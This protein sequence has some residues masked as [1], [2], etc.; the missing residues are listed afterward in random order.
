MRK[1][2][3]AR[4]F[5][6]LSAVMLLLGTGCGSSGGD[7]DD[8]RI[9]VAMISDYGG[10]DDRS[11]N[12]TTYE[13]EKGFCTDRGIDYTYFKPEGDSDAERVAM[14]DMAAAQRY[15]VILLPGYAFAEPLAEA[16]EMYPDIK[17]IGLDISESD[18]AAAAGTEHYSKDNV[19]SAVYKEQLSGFMAGYMAVKQGY[20]ELGF[21]GGM[22]VPG[23]KRA[24]FGFV[25][26]CDAAAGEL[27][28]EVHLKYSYSNSFVGDA[29]ITAAMDM[30]YSDKT[31]IV[32]A[33]GG[34]IYTSVA[35]AAKKTGGKIIGVDTD[36]SEI[37]DSVYGDG[38]TVTSAMKGLGETVRTVLGAICDGRWDDFKGRNESLGVVSADEPSANYVQL[39][40]DSTQWSDRFTKEDYRE[41]LEKL[42]NGEMQVSDDISTDIPQVKSIRVDFQDSIK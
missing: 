29:D 8:N 3:A 23:V 7:N 13:A 22:A 15:N 5:A 2:A 24:G 35:E 10:I 37:I 28:T 9:R 27:G 32:F 19:Y 1:A 26:G 30:W 18:L 39:P 40:E 21:L 38:I 4:V 36:Q 34:G 41:L 31:E 16:A 20:T 25:Q 42:M 33:C 17:F 6:L 14:I 11:F 12:Q